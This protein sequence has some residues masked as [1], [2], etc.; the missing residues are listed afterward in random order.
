MLRTLDRSDLK[1][2]GPTKFQ[3][4]VK[5][6]ASRA[7]EMKSNT[8]VQSYLILLILTDG[9]IN[10]LEKTKQAVIAATKLPLSIII[11]GVGSA[12][13]GKMDALDSDDENLTSGGKSAK[14]DIVQFVPFRSFLNKPTSELAEAVLAEVPAQF[15]EYMT[16]QGIKPHPPPSETEIADIQAKRA[17]IQKSLIFQYGATPNHL[18]ESTLANPVPQ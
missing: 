9:E 16:T 14:R 5:A 12:D 7:K 18:T 3:K 4:I 6:A 2:N 13:F 15:M 8:D 1:L 17:Q 11:I 10:D